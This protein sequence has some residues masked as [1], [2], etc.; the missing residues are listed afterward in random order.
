MSFRP[1]VPPCRNDPG[2]EAGVWVWTR[3]HLGS[4]SMAGGRRLVLHRQP[5][6][7]SPSPL[8]ASDSQ[9]ALHVV[10][11]TGV[12]DAQV[13]RQLGDLMRSTCR[14]SF[15]SASRALSTLSQYAALSSPPPFPSPTPQVITTTSYHRYTSILQRS[16]RG[17]HGNVV[18][19]CCNP[20]QCQMYKGVI[21]QK[22]ICAS[23]QV[24]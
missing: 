4:S 17:S 21:I 12:S 23:E 9:V 6:R 2:G 5:P 7:P 1:R 24:D 13:D 14:E 8:Q 19:T 15:N 11:V 16:G 20:D 10:T 18:P 3:A 22:E